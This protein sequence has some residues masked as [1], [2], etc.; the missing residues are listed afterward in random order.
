MLQIFLGGDRIYPYGAN[1]LLKKQG[2][3]SSSAQDSK[4]PL[5]NDPPAEPVFP[6]TEPAAFQLSDFSITYALDIQDPEDPDSQLKY[7]EVRLVSADD[8]D[9]ASDDPDVVWN[10]GVYYRRDYLW[11]NSSDGS[12]LEPGRV[13]S[14]FPGL[15]HNQNQSFYLLARAYD[16]E[17]NA[18]VQVAVSNPVNI[19]G[20][21][22]PYRN[23]PGAKVKDLTFD[24]VDHDHATVSWQIPNP[25]AGELFNVDQLNVAIV[26]IVK[27]SALPA[28]LVERNSW[29][30][31]WFY[32]Q[33]HPEIILFRQGWED[34]DHNEFYPTRTITK[35]L[36]KEGLQAL[37]GDDYLV[38]VRT[39][40]GG[41]DYS[42]TVTNEAAGTDLP[43]AAPAVNLLFDYNDWQVGASVT[44]PLN[45]GGDPPTA[46]GIPV[47][48]ARAMSSMVYVVDESGGDPNALT[49]AEVTYYYPARLAELR[50]RAL[51]GGNWSK[52]RAYQ[53]TYDGMTN[54]TNWATH[55]NVFRGGEPYTFD[56]T[57]ASESDWEGKKA[58]AL[59]WV[60]DM[61]F[62]ASPI[63]FS[64][65]VTIERPRPGNPIN[66]WLEPAQ[67]TSGQYLEKIMVG[68]VD[69]PTPPN[70]EDWNKIDH[71]T[72][73][74]SA[75]PRTAEQ[76]QDNDYHQVWA[77][78]IYVDYPGVATTDPTGLA[79]HISALD[80]DP[81]F[82][83][84]NRSDYRNDPI[85]AP[86]GSGGYVYTWVR[87]T[88]RDGYET[89]IETD[90][91][92]VRTRIYSSEDAGVLSK[93]INPPYETPLTAVGGTAAITLSWPGLDK[94]VDG[95][96]VV[97]PGKYSYRVAVGAIGPDNYLH[98]DYQGHLQ[99]SVSGADV[100]YATQ[101]R[102]IF[103]RAALEAVAD[104][105][106]GLDFPA[107]SR[108]YFA[109]SVF[110]TV[111][112]TKGD[113]LSYPLPQSLYMAP[114]DEP[115]KPNPDLWGTYLYEAEPY[116]WPTAQLSDNPFPGQSNVFISR[117]P[118]A[119]GEQVVFHKV[120]AGA[121]EIKIF[122]L[123]DEEV[124]SIPV[125]SQADVTW[126][127]QNSRGAK[128]GDGVYYFVVL[129]GGQKPDKHNKFLV[130]N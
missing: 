16:T 69:L 84:S 91:Q 15:D 48:Q 34:F 33:E 21:N 41:G 90:D 82:Y 127:V 86:P 71:L 17:G 51:V 97:D 108:F 13:N 107:D 23:I 37:C 117:N 9:P 22:D 61:E 72:I 50:D 44:P 36:V 3:E 35:D 30:E 7:I 80:P 123:N 116:P 118:V 42:N 128:L 99:N 74:A 59:A 110:T 45:E 109:V 119:S 111:V 27:R 122:T 8:F 60:E 92:V 130:N 95:N 26:R 70:D 124:T 114:N 120:P 96:E 1:S 100:H 64:P 103:D 105:S 85:E 73:Y 81:R 56:F 77:T 125:N 104:S 87:A 101:C 49:P 121:S 126:T 11:D 83:F 57:A 54:D 14:L 115:V 106:L 62:N 43:P 112:T 68:S 4:S 5:L 88:T 63:G 93:G 53:K 52:V 78:K 113:T 129:G 10:S 98:W 67:A 25:A 58:F 75:V 47:D 89:E 39:F 6:E 40:D 79:P 20:G 29:N 2:T 76:I 55:Y 94:T 19:D 31:A 65:I 66:F 38:M 46:T 12:E 102:K 32:A 24:W 28:E 18:S